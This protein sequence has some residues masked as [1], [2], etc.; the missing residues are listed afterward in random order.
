MFTSYCQ[1]KTECCEEGY[2]LDPRLD[3]FS[4]AWD[5]RF[6]TLTS[7]FRDLAYTYFTL[8]SKKWVI[9]N[10]AT[11]NTYDESGMWGREYSGF[12]LPETHKEESDIL[13]ENYQTKWRQLPG[14]EKSKT[15]MEE[16]DR[17]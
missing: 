13:W 4:L 9:F 8:C 2:P 3:H 11:P 7:R 1:A 6:E 15:N 10:T 5:L 14:P 16:P 17:L 12:R